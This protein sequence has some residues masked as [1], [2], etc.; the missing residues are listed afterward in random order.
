M[1]D[2]W[3]DRVARNI[4]SFDIDLENVEYVITFYDDEVIRIPCYYAT[5]V[6][7]E[8]AIFRAVCKKKKVW[9]YL[10]VENDNN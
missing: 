6:S 1:V 4:T 2:K 7:K 3:Q 5:F 9:E 10:A 8:E